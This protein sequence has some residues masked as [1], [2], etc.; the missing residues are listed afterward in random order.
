MAVSGTGKVNPMPTPQQP[1]LRRSE[2]TPGLAPDS[3][4]GELDSKKRPGSSGATGPVPAGNRAGS[5]S[6]PVQDKPDLDRFAEKLGITDE[7]VEHADE[8]MAEHQEVPHRGL[9]RPL[10]WA[11]YGVGGAVGVV[12]AIRKLAERRARHQSPLQRVRDLLPV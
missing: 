6:G 4:A 2:T 3:I 10:V 8:V 9:P 12:A 1:E 7:A 11:A 5:S